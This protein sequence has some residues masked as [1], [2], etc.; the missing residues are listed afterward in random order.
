MLLTQLVA[1]STPFLRGT[2]L[3][4]KMSQNRTPPN[5]S[6]TSTQNDRQYTGALFSGRDVPCCV[7]HLLTGVKPPC[8]ATLRSHCNRVRGRTHCALT[9]ETV[10]CA[11]AHCV[12]LGN[13]LQRRALF[14]AAMSSVQCPPR[15][16]SSVPRSSVPHSLL[17]VTSPKSFLHLTHDSNA[18]VL[19]AG[20][21]P[22]MHGPRICLAS[23]TVRKPDP[24]LGHSRARYTTVV[25]GMA[26]PHTND[27]T[28]TKPPSAETS[29][30]VRV[31]TL[32]GSTDRP[33][34][35]PI[36]GTDT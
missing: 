15:L 2:R 3:Q 35:L 5:C 24:C 31:P 32:Q 36:T 34:K 12:V 8:R 26:Q 21:R 33:E 6:F 27:H 25:R 18:V 23:V 16:S 20:P 4:P 30:I 29:G 9:L 1:I 11:E 13:F 19:P 17:Q 28:T 10:H 22:Q 14:H 7:F